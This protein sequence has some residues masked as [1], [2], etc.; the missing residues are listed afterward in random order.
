[1]RK[2]VEQAAAE[3]VLW[4]VLAEPMWTVVDLSPSELAERGLGRTLL[5]ESRLMCLGPLLG[6]CSTLWWTSSFPT[7]DSPPISDC[8]QD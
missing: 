3:L 2:R 5:L 6:R 4:Y 8:A 7:V 1:M